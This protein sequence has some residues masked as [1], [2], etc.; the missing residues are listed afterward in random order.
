MINFNGT[1]LTEVHYN[2]VDLDSVWFC[3]S[4]AGTC[5]EV[6]SK[7]KV[8]IKTN[9]N[10]PSRQW[11][12][13]GSVV[14][15]ADAYFQDVCGTPFAGYGWGIAPSVSEMFAVVDF[16]N[17][18]CVRFGTYSFNYNSNTEFSIEPN[19]ISSSSSTSMSI[20]GYN[21]A[22]SFNSVSTSIT[23][24]P[25]TCTLQACPSGTNT[26]TDVAYFNTN[27]IS[28]G[29]NC[30]T[31]DFGTV[32]I[33][34]STVCACYDSVNITACGVTCT[35]SLDDLANGVTLYFSNN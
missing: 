10:T 15:S 3:D 2:G 19:I 20:S 16:V 4:T 23:V 22:A 33:N 28:S 11:S 24:C 13:S 26:S 6:F 29:I 7:P 14:D 9:I 8:Y 18:S 1:T 34:T 21:S 27:A 31:N 17:A 12:T 32:Y 30:Y 5:T 35:V 25:I